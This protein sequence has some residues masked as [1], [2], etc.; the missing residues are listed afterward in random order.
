MQDESV[1][2]EDRAEAKRCISSSQSSIHIK[3]QLFDASQLILSQS[4]SNA[5]MLRGGASVAALSNLSC[6]LFLVY[7]FFCSPSALWDVNWKQGLPANKCEI[8][9]FSGLIMCCTATLIRGLKSELQ[10]SISGN[11]RN[12]SSGNFR[13]LDQR[14]SGDRYSE[15]MGLFEFLIRQVSTGAFLL[16]STVRY[17]QQFIEGTTDDGDA[18]TPPFFPSEKNEPM[19]GQ[20]R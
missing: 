5:D 1:R 15:G 18:R 2:T 8:Q 12:Q 14:L 10:S 9:I 20:R 3:V 6:H 13:I 4:Q 19:F 7:R 11:S 17:G 16:R